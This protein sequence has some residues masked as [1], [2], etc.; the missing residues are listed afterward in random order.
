MC[1]E[2]VLNAVVNLVNDAVNYREVRCFPDVVVHSSP[3]FLFVLQPL[4]ERDKNGETREH[5]ER[6]DLLPYLVYQ[7]KCTMCD[8][9]ARVT[10]TSARQSLT[11]LW[12]ILNEKIAHAEIKFYVLV[13][14]T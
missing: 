14:Q 2:F 8:E 7:K 3:L 12:Q 9:K 4:R 10:V 1:G 5:D 11:T 6:E 13:R